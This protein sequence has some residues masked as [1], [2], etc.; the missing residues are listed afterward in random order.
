MGL[1][2]QLKTIILY[3]YVLYAYLGHKVSIGQ[4]IKALFRIFHID[5]ENPRK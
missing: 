4:L 5:F 3:Y 1:V 2:I